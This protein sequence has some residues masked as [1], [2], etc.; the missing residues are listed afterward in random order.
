LLVDGH[1]RSLVVEAIIMTRTQLDGPAVGS[2]GAGVHVAR[3]LPVLL[4]TLASGLAAV[5]VL[6]PLMTGAVRYHYSASMLN[7]AIGLD[8]FAL[9]VVVPV[10][11]VSAVLCRRAHPAGPLLAMAP[12][13]F[14]A[15]M[16]VQYVI[17]PEYLRVDGNSERVFLLF[18]A[19][20]VTAM[21]TLLVAWSRAA[22]PQVA[23]ASLRRRGITLLVLA[24][25]VVLGM[26]LANGF[27]SAMTDFPKYV[28]ERAAVSEYDEHPTAYWIV[29]FLDLG[30]VVPTTVATGLGLLRNSAWARKAFYGVVGWFALVPGSVAAMA[31]VM[32]L[33]SDPAGSASKALVFAV[34]AAA[35][36]AAAARVFVPLL[37][38]RGSA[39]AAPA[40]RPQTAWTGTS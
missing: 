15:Y 19:L 6:G 16:L 25:F 27:V 34:V 39:P 17:G 7:Q 20:F 1:R 37:R 35:C 32:V 5:A 3:T 14:A 18:V 21:A 8:A 38:D 10:A 30:V 13:G 28:A 4:V 36:I 29:A 22:A 33:R 9:F 23:Q 12:A 2:V 31:V 40:E 24:A 11:L 26:Y